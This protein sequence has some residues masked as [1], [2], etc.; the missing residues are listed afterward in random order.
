VE[1]EGIFLDE[2]C[3][4]CEDEITKTLRLLE[5]VEWLE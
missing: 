4:V 5:G 2:C 1:M 3:F